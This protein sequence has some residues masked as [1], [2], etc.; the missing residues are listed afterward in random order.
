MIKR[1]HRQLKASLIYYPNIFWVEAF[2]LTLLGLR[3]VFKENI[4]ASLAELVYGEPF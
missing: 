2:P 3:N 4:Q 1:L